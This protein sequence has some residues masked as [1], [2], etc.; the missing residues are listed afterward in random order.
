MLI[1]LK[2]SSQIVDKF[3]FLKRCNGHIKGVKLCLKI[4]KLNFHDYILQNFPHACKKSAIS[5]F[6]FLV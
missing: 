4:F 6:S 2:I 1:V 3:D 5:F